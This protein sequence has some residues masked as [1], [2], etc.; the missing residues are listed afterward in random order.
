M[1]VKESKDRLITRVAENVARDAEIRHQRFEEAVK[2]ASPESVAEA[3][4]KQLDKFTDTGV[5]DIFKGIAQGLSETFPDT[6]LRMSRPTGNP[7]DEMVVALNYLFERQSDTEIVYH[8]IYGYITGQSSQAT[9]HIAAGVIHP[10]EEER[11]DLSLKGSGEITGGVADSVIPYITDAV[12]V[13]IKAPQD[14]RVPLSE[15]RQFQ[16]IPYKA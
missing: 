9:L 8:Q 3:Q 16:L 12:G 11:T 10:V 1:P 6:E 14:T 15:P 4:Q 2:K 13:A 7:A 5:L